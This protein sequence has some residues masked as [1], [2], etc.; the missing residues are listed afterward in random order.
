MICLLDANP[1]HTRAEDLLI[2]EQ[3]GRQG[4]LLLKML[5]LGR[6]E[7]EFPGRLGPGM[8]L[9]PSL[10]L[11]VD[12]EVRLLRETGGSMEL[13]IAELD[14]PEELREA[15]VRWTVPFWARRAITGSASF[16]AAA[17]ASLLPEAIASSTLRTELRSLVRR[18]LLT[19]VQRTV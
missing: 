19:S 6:P 1:R 2:L 11:I 16:K 18:P 14:D 15:V 7:S 17:A 9:R 3:V 4:S 13:A 5:A 10:E 8:L 12:A